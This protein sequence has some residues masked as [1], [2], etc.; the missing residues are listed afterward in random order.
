MIRELRMEMSKLTW[1]FRLKPK[2]GYKLR[3]TLLI[4]Q[5]LL[6][7]K[8]IS[9]KLIQLKLQPRELILLLIQ[10]HSNKRKLIS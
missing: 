1:L 7:M 10:H 4:H 8:M 2:A 3:K 9:Q 5:E 6:N